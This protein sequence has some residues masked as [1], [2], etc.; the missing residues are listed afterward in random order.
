[1]CDVDNPLFEK[2]GAAYVFGPQKGTDKT[3]VKFLDSGL[4]HLPQVICEQLER[5]ISQ[6]SGTG[7]A[8]GMGAW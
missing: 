6:L 4:R 1:M 5:D 8:D 7:A 2:N 3:M